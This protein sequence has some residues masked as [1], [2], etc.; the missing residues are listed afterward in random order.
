MAVYER[1][2]RGYS[3]PVTPARWRFLIITRYACR[4]VFQARLFGAFFTACFAF[5]VACALTIY[6]QHNLS[7][8]AVLKIPEQALSQI[9]TEFFRVFVVVQDWL[10]F[11]LALFIGPA[12]VSPDLANN[13][14]ALYLCRPFS[15]AEYVLGKLS[16]LAILMSLITWVPGILL[17]LFRAFLEGGGWMM[18][19]L[20]LAGALLLGFWVTILVFS[21]MALAASAWVKHKLLAAALVLGSFFVSGALAVSINLT[22]RTRLG[23]LINL[24]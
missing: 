14:L 18:A 20:R 5:P 6:L 22:L 10:A 21:L 19:N 3:G 13:G 4:E 16:V 17:F 12:L 1:T 8:L 11:L 24:G 7:A 2:Y 23:H 9:V 15:R